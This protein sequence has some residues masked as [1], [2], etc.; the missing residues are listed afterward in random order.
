MFTGPRLKNSKADYK[1]KRN[2]RK[3]YPLN[4]TRLVSSATVGRIH[5]MLKSLEQSK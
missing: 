5:I 1:I 2:E 3:S 4:S